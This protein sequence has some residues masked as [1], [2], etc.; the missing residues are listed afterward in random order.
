VSDVAREPFFPPASNGFKVALVLVVLT[1]IPLFY[2]SPG[3][4]Q[5]RNMNR[6]Q[7][8]LDRV[9]TSVFADP[10]FKDTRAVVS[11]REEIWILGTLKTHADRDALV[12]ALE[13]TGPRCNVKWTGEVLEDYE[14]AEVESP[15]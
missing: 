13:A 5:Y 12:S 6:I 3:C 10:R 4:R 8:H 15:P 9:S 14:Q 7:R 11:T 2:L 1:F